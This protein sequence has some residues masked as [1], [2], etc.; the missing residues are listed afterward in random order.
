MQKWYF[1]IVAK[2]TISSAFKTRLSDKLMDLGNYTAVGLVIGQFVAGQ[3]I[4]Q[5]TLVGGIIG[6][7]ILYLAGYIVSS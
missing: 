7:A 3:Q 4:S 6:A 2:L 1:N 5:E